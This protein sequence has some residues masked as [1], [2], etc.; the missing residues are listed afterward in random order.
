M[1]KFKLLKGR[2][3]SAVEGELQGI[4]TSFSDLS[5]AAPLTPLYCSILGRYAVY[6]VSQQ[7]GMTQPTAALAIF[8]RNIT[9]LKKSVNS[10][11][12]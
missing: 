1:F 9:D 8:F 3:R 11:Y 10:D 4:V 12:Y 2:S 7:H 6:G 5:G